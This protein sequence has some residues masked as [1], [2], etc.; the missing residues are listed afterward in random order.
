M[1]EAETADLRP[2]TA[3]ILSKLVE[4]FL[5]T[6]EPVGSRTLSKLGI[7][8]SPATIR[9]E[10]SDL[11]DAGYVEQ[12]HTSA[13]RIPT[14]RGYRFWLD[15]LPV[16]DLDAVKRDEARLREL[17]QRYLQECRGLRNL[18]SNS[19][20]I[21]SEVCH[22]AGVASLPSLRDS[23]SRVQLIG[24]DGQ[25]VMVVMV[26]E[27][28]LA[29]SHVLT[30]ENQMTQEELNNLSAFLNDSSS[31]SSLVHLVQ[32][33]VQ[34]MRRLE[35]RAQDVAR[36]LMDKLEAALLQAETELFYDGLSRL[37][38]S[39]PE[40]EE[41]MEGLLTSFGGEGIVPLLHPGTDGVSVRVGRENSLRELEDFS[42][43]TARYGGDGLGGG[44]IGILGPKRMNYR[45]VI[46]VVN[47]MRRRLEEL[48]GH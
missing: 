27:T 22:V 43:V 28:G 23:A 42:L 1:N 41:R 17:D 39:L 26:G 40:S 24:L 2:R 15:S 31:Q 8:A 6:G 32:N 16:E 33:R 20:R 37:F 21:L 45:R 7:E 38:H 29:T 4:H 44:T 46:G 35:R 14:D 5:E 19:A 18:V 10:V 34:V 30:V 48:V 9:N 25:H 13:G 36:E 47:H 12:P 11:E 3:L